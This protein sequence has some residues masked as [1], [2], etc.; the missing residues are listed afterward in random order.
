MNLP[1]QELSLPERWPPDY[2]IPGRE[3]YPEQKMFGDALTTK[4]LV[5]RIILI[6]LGLKA[7]NH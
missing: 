6:F 1:A 3:Y 5:K 4:V 7:K 2:L